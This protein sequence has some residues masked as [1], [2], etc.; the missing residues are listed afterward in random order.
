MKERLLIISSSRTNETRGRKKPT[1]WAWNSKKAPSFLLAH[2]A[3]SWTAGTLYSIS[4]PLRCAA[5]FAVFVFD[6]G[7][8]ES[9]VHRTGEGDRSD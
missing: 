2:A 8:S 4:R 3:L 6:F 9:D 7:R 5:D 1:P